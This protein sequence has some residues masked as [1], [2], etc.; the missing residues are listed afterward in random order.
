MLEATVVVMLAVIVAGA[1][2]L[3]ERR[4]AV[5]YKQVMSRLGFA[6]WRQEALNSN[7]HELAH[8]Q[9]GHSHEV[10]GAFRKTVDG[11]NVTLF[12]HQ[13]KCRRLSRWLDGYYRDEKIKQ[14]VLLCQAPGLE[15]PW[16][17]LKP[18]S[19][20]DKLDHTVFGIQDID[21]A[22]DPDFSRRYVLQG[23]DIA[24]IQQTLTPSIRAHLAQ[25]PGMSVE[26]YGD[27]LLYYHD[28]KLI[29]PSGLAQFVDDGVSL[30]TMLR[31]K[32]A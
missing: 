6:E 25:H 32:E 17:F 20:G 3:Y 31:G 5:D 29:K 15:L 1:G 27:M 2:Y 22:E 4:K 11:A 8:F 16:L 7:A 26:A 23:N 9:E 12:T 21:F 30:M 19:I 28:R 18:E 14:T 24:R 13:Y 10:R